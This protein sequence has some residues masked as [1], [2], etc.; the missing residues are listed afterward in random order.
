M[1][2]LI[3]TAPIPALLLALAC[4][5]EAQ[6]FVPSIDPQAGDID[7]PELAFPV[8][9]DA[10]STLIGSTNPGLD[11][12]WDDAQ[13]V[14]PVL[15]GSPGYGYG[16][17]GYFDAGTGWSVT[18]GQPDSQV[19]HRI[20]CATPDGYCEFLLPDPVVPGVACHCEGSA[21]AGVTE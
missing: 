4:T 20:T 2:T 8:S 14:S 11:D 15:P 13:S 7:L 17:D 19:F 3:A 16:T 1:A 9:P 6:G 18:S 10:L 21:E 12:V 5:A